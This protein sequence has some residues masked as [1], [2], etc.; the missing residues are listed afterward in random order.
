MK[1]YLHG[2]GEFGRWGDCYGLGGLYS[3]TAGPRGGIG[4]CG[5]AGRCLAHQ[6]QFSLQCHKHN[7]HCLFRAR[8]CCVLPC[9]FPSYMKLG[10]FTRGSGLGT[11]V[12]MAGPRMAAQAL[13]KFYAPKLHKL[14]SKAEF[15]A[16]D[17]TYVIGGEITIAAPTGITGTNVFHVQLLQADPASEP[18][19]SSSRISRVSTV[20]LRLLRL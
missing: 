5:C 13:H 12:G 4:S 8:G 10:R 17:R 9:A 19:F 16:D 6:R 11:E 20:S 18:F 1:F 7:G 2:E 15:S 3:L 14:G